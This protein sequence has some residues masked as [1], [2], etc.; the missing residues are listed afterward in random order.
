MLLKELLG[1]MRFDERD[2]TWNY[3]YW[4]AVE[5]DNIECTNLQKIALDQLV[6]KY[7]NISVIDYWSFYDQKRGAKIVLS[8]EGKWVYKFTLKYELT[9]DEMKFYG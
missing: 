9:L 5:R 6:E 8:P 2:S 3:W 4:N 1:K 7:P